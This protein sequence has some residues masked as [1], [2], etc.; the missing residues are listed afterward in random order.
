VLGQQTQGIH[1]LHWDGKNWLGQTLASGLYFYQIEAGALI[2]T[3][4]LLLIR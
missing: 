1:T 4:K 3:K 2:L